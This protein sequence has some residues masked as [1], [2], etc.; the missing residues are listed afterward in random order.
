MDLDNLEKFRSLDRSNML[1]Q[2][3]S[4]P[5]QFEKAWQL[6]LK[7]PLPEMKPVKKIVVAGMG[8]SAIGADLL[9]AYLAPVC[10]LPFIV[11]RDYG[12]PGWVN[13]S[14]TLVVASSHSGNTEE[15]LSAFEQALENHCQVIAISTGG[16]L[17]LNAKAAGIPTWAF[18]HT[19]QPRAA[20]GF[21]FGL[22]LALTVRLGLLADPAE[23]VADTVRM[24]V[25]QQKTLNASVPVKENPA[26][27]LAG[28][29]VGRNV[30]VIGS[31]FLAPVARRWKTQ[32]NELAKA[33]AAFETLPE[34]DHNTLASATYPEDV[35]QKMMVVFLRSALE[36][37][38]N[39]LRSEKTQEILMTEGLGTD[40]FKPSGGT[41]LAQMWSAIQFG[42]YLSYYLA[43]AYEVDPTP[44]P[45]IQGLKDAL[46]K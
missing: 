28:Q 9:S 44:I 21:S 1:G 31:G 25:E 3:E 29:L 34:V 35:L 32:I 10:P 27:R 20:V 41:T 13:G 23:E 36:H 33:W 46:K 43:M 4:L 7:Q 8:G 40:V 11:H 24:M 39:Y 12:L 42:D 17:Q 30:T 5:A 45:L 15:T 18:Q 37:P 16:T 2:I 19:G 22:L 14:D 38:R 26:K 6:G